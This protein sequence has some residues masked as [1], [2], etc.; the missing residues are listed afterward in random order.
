M[1]KIKLNE[2]L[3]E[4]NEALLRQEYKDALRLF[5]SARQESPGDSTAR[6]S[7]YRAATELALHQAGL[8]PFQ[9][10]QKGILVL[11]YHLIPPRQHT[12]RYKRVEQIWLLNPT[13]KRTTHILI[14]TAK[15]SGKIKF[16]LQALQALSQ[17]QPNETALMNQLLELAR[18]HQNTTIEIEALEALTRL[19]PNNTELAT[20]LQTAKEKNQEATD[21]TITLKKQLE[22][23]P[24]NVELRMQYL[25]TQLRTRQFDQAIAE[26]TAY[27]SEQDAPQPRLEKRLFLAREHQINFKLAAAQDEHNIALIDQLRKQSDQLRI[28]QVQ[29]Q[30]TRSPNDLQLRFDYAKIL[31]DCREWKEALTQFQ[32]AIHHRKRRIR[33]LIYSAD[34]YQKLNQSD[35]AQEQLETALTELPN[36]TREKT[37]IENTLQQLQRG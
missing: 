17:A 12:K 6:K 4:G 24:H 15:Q 35:H 32:H 21:P 26:L 28:E 27:L 37:E 1:K 36:N 9:R 2:L 16:A 5:Q 18:E 8:T 11:S 7:H 19:H 33:A 34:I 31:Y 22:Q 23:D 29:L 20:A 30:V 13:C 10:L 3:H 14:Q 25:D